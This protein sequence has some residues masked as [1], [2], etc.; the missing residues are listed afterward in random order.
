MKPRVLYRSAGSTDV[1]QAA[2]LME[3]LRQHLSDYPLHRVFNVDETDLFLS[4]YRALHT[5]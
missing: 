5:L 4:S 1:E 2:P 3:N